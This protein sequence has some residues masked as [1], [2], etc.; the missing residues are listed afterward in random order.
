MN[1]QEDWLQGGENGPVFN[2]EAPSKSKVL[3]VIQSTDPDTVMPP[4]AKDR[5]RPSVEQI[6][7]LKN[8]V[9]SGANWEPGYAFQKPTYNAPVAHRA[10]V[11]PPAAKGLEHPLDRLLDAYLQANGVQLPP[12][13]DDATFARRVHLDLIGLLPE[14]AALREFVESKAGNKREKLIDALLARSTDYTEH[15]LT[16]WNDLLRNDYGGTGFI[17]GG[18]KQISAWLYTALHSNPGY[19]LAGHRKRQPDTGNPIRAVDLASFPRAKPQVRLL[20]R[21]LYRQMETHRRVRTGGGVC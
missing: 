21:Q 5:A 6:S 20:S 11:L 14:P 13:C 18:R 4:P 12:L 1:S 2:S 3:E 15:W 7:I 9:L 8:W 10:P 16:F 17:T 19:H